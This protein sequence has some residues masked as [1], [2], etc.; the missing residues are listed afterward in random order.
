MTSPADAIIDLYQRHAATYDGLRGKTLMEGPWLA[1]FRDLLAPGA[2]IL[3]IGCGTGQPIARHFIEHGHAVTGV[4]SAPAMIA[5]CRTRFP[6]GDWQV[7]DM[8]RLALGRRFDGLIAWD[9]FFHL[10][11]EDQRGMFKVFAS[12]AAPGAA[13]LF[14]SG[15]AHG[16]AIGSFESEALYHGSL[17][18]GEYRTL[19]AESGFAV[20][21]HIVEDPSC[22][23]H[24]IWLAAAAQGVP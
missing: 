3:D 8:R 15:P 11:P 14:T 17:D 12:H 2:T 13:L 1:R 10:T 23:G 24:T 19:L 21:D 4:D 22:G 9:S 18:P 16:E 7:A 20:I 6:E 5:L